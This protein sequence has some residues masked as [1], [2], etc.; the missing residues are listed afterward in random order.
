MEVLKRFREALHVVYQGFGKFK[1]I[2]FGGEQA[3]LLIEQF[4]EFFYCLLEGL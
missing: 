2:L 4:T 3:L 1:F